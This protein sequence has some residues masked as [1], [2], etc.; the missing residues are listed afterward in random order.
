MICSETEKNIDYLWSVN[1]Y[2][3]VFMVKFASFRPMGLNVQ[4]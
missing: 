4:S 3:N 2:Q 1:F